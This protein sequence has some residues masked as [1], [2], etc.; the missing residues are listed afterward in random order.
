M[1]V[2]QTTVWLLIGLWVSAFTS[3]TLLP[4]SS[5]I[6]LGTLWW[7]GLNIFLI[8]SVATFGNVCGS[9]INW[10]LGTQVH[11]FSQRRWFPVTP[12]QLEKAQV[13]F[14]RFG[15]P[16]L[17]LTGLPLIGDPLTV[18]AGVFRV[19]FLKTILLI[20][21]AKGG[22]YA[23]LLVMADEWLKPLINTTAG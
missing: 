15:T 1:N 5:E 2:A 7:Q 6:V 12:V 11:R 17:L 3:A 21:I 18:A 14:D 9:M 13:H 22:R 23:L 4:G 16:A 10:W 8:W 20:F 19:S